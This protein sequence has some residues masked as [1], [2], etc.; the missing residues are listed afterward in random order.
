MFLINFQGFFGKGSLSR[1]GPEFGKVKK[2]LPPYLRNRQWLRRKEW[3][4]EQEKIERAANNECISKDQMLMDET[5][6]EKGPAETENSVN[7]LVGPAKS[8]E[9][10]VATAGPSGNIPQRTTDNSVIGDSPKN[11][12]ITLEVP[13]VNIVQN[14]SKAGPISNVA[15]ATLKEMDVVVLSDEEAPKRRVKCLNSLEEIEVI[16]DSSSDAVCKSD[17]HT[18]TREGERTTKVESAVGKE[19]HDIVEDSSPVHEVEEKRPDVK[20]AE[21]VIDIVDTRMHVDVPVLADCSG[22]RNKVEK[23]ECEEN[24]DSSCSAEVVM[25]QDSDNRSGTDVVMVEDADNS[26]GG[27][28]D[29]T[30]VRNDDYD[31]SESEESDT[32]EQCKRTAGDKRG[33]KVLVLPDSDSEDEGYK[34][35][36][37]NLRARLEWEQF[38]VR[39]TLHLSLEEAYF[40]SYGLGCLQV[41]DPFGNVLSLVDIWKMFREAQ[42]D[43]VPKY[44]AYHYLRAKGWIVRSGLKYGGDFSKYKVYCR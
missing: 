3:A 27:G 41:L 5:D 7:E 35:Y 22:S 33:S 6:T 39:E 34:S 12:V 18:A 43:F 10:N 15:T 28:M 26:C 16:D 8:G 32:E 36:V 29:V 9:V 20:L 44:V 37:K 11:E 21:L 31:G 4:E 13:D 1:G 23:A 40:L 2:N 19:T 14:V 25:V 38:S 30:Q 17:M 24:K 42:R